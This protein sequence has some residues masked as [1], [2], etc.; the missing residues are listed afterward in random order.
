MP[1]IAVHAMVGIVHKAHAFSM[2]D[3]AFVRGIFAAGLMAVALAAPASAQDNVTSEIEILTPLALTNTRE[4][5]FGGI[6]APRNGRVDMTAEETATCTTNNNLVH[7]GACQS[8][9]FDGRAIAGQNITITVPTGRRF[10]IAGPDSRPLRVR[11]VT[12]GD[13]TGLTFQGR[14]GNAYRYQVSS[15]DGL[16]DFHIGARLLI[17]NNQ[18]PGVYSGTFTINLEYQ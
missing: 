17:R 11:R 3:A 9:A 6:V 8:A 5:D 4:L 12:V 1:S 15:T 18:A 14:T 16:F 7:S 10:E 2:G 13:A